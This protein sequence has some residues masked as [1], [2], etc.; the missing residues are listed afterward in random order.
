MAVSGGDGPI[1]IWDMLENAVSQR[2]NSRNSA[3]V[4]TFSSDDSLLATGSITTDT[5]STLHLWNMA[6]GEIEDEFPTSQQ[7]HQVLFDRSG[8][9]LITLQ[10]DP[11]YFQSH[12]RF[13][14]PL[15]SNYRTVQV[16]DMITTKN[17]HSRTTAPRYG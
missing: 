10:T 13:G 15:Y 3:L 16:W 12:Y 5:A 4:T 11:T 14:T 2:L 7:I 6:T 8:Q 9:K 17:S 1:L